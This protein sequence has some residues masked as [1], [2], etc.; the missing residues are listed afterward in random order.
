MECDGYIPYFTSDTIVTV[1]CPS[2]EDEETSSN[3]INST[4]SCQNLGSTVQVLEWRIVQSVMIKPLRPSDAIWRQRSWTTL[5]QVMACCLTAPSHYLNQCRLIITEV[6]WHSSERNSQQIPQ[7]PITKIGLKIT[8]PKFHSNLPG[9]NELNQTSPLYHRLRCLIF[10]WTYINHSKVFDWENKK[11][12][13]MLPAL[14]AWWRHHG[15]I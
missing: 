2:D 6:Y 9:A 12:P 5:A 13:H 8:Y 1:S 14:Y 4:C 7:P 11:N 10:Q 3:V 15:S